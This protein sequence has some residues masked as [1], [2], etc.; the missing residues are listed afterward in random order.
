MSAYARD[1]VFEMVVREDDTPI[2]AITK[3][4]LDKMVTDAEKYPYSETYSSEYANTRYN[5]GTIPETE[6]QET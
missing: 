5:E 3:E 4:Q 6:N 1:F 2:P